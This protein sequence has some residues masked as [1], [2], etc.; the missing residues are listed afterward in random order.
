MLAYALIEPTES[1]HPGSLLLYRVQ[2]RKADKSQLRRIDLPEM[3]QSA[4]Q[5]HISKPDLT[6]NLE[7]KW[8]LKN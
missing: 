3:T 1:D 6:E 4:T 5:T 2:L 7:L 8:V